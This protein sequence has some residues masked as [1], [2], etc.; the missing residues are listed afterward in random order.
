MAP[1]RAVPFA[2]IS[3]FAPALARVPPEMGRQSGRAC[4]VQRTA[5][6]CDARA[7]AAEG[8]I[9]PRWRN[10]PG[11]ALPEAALARPAM[12]NF[13]FARRNGGDETGR[14]EATW[15]H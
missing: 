4:R 14:K 11:E 9:G 7:M 12:F 1:V 15:R 8:R 3:L 6:V 10:R 5:G 2:P 13:A